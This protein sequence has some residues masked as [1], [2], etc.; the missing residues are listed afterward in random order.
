MVSVRERLL[1]G[2]LM[3]GLQMVKVMR[4]NVEYYFEWSIDGY[5]A[6]GY[7]GAVFCSFEMI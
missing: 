3:S 4:S 5:N 1:S 6:V 2:I 7:K